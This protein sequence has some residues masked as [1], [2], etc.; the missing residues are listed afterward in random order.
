MRNQTLFEF[1]ITDS[2]FDLS[3][4]KTDSDIRRTADF[5]N[6]GRHTRIGLGCR[7]S[8]SCFTFLQTSAGCPVSFQ[9]GNILTVKD[10]SANA[11]TFINMIGT[12]RFFF[13]QSENGDAVNGFSDVFQH[14]VCYFSA[15]AAVRGFSR[16]ETVS[17][18]GFFFSALT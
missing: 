4:F 14:G 15:A 16:E 8:D 18:Y 13:F 2:C 11:S 5:G 6:D 10:V 7:F 3:V 1:G 17:G 9:T 12:V